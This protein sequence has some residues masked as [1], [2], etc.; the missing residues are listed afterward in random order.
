M[1]SLV[2]SLPPIDHSEVVKVM[3]PFPNSSAVKLPISPL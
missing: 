2:A 3:D 1:M